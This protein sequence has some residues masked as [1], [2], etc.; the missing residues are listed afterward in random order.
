[1]DAAV[2]ARPAVMD[3]VNVALRD[4]R[5]ARWNARS[6]PRVGDFLLRRDGT[7]ARFTYDHGPVIQTTAKGFG[8]GSFY[9]AD[10]GT[11]DYSGAL[12]P[13][14]TKMRLEDTGEFEDGACWF[15]SHDEARAHNGVTCVVPCRVYRLKD[16]WADL[17]RAA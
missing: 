13:W 4:A 8:P 15:F 5:V 12:D 16:E 7:L 11:M 2:T 1:M 14:L 10:D 9:F 3:D 17:V 6:G